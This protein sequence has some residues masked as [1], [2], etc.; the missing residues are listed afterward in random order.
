MLR[1]C[2]IIGLVSSEGSAKAQPQ[3]IKS[4]TTNRQTDPSRRKC[5]S[6]AIQNNQCVWCSLLL[7]PQLRMTAV[8]GAHS[9]LSM[10]VVGELHVSDD[11]WLKV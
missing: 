1:T 7:D 5:F 3:S 8:E 4:S 2:G 11:T 6:L 10:A 9:Q